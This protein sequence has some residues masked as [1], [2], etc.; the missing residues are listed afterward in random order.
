MSQSAKKFGTPLVLTQWVIELGHLTAI[1]AR[2]Q[3]TRDIANIVDSLIMKEPK[4]DREV[5]QT[6]ITDIEKVRGDYKPHI[7]HPEEMFRYYDEGLQLGKRVDDIL[8][9]V[10]K[11]I[12]KFDLID[13]SG[14]TEGPG[15]GWGSVEQRE[16]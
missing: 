15:R 10:F 2:I 6:A 14:I 7:D 5:I 1:G 4:T 9:E 11:I 3:K 16:G 8:R 13:P 12:T